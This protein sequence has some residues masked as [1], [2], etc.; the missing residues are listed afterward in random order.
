LVWPDAG[1][2]RLFGDSGPAALR[3]VGS[4]IETPSLYDHLTG[5]EN[6]DIPRRLL[7]LPA[8]E[9]GRVLEIVGLA[10][11]A[12][13]RVGGYSLGMRQRLAI[14]RALLG[15]PRLLILDEPANG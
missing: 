13:Q 14:A 9:I 4:L 15:S 1:T 3:E 11:A 10:H 2:I 5:R 6:L 7:G 12:R 8:G